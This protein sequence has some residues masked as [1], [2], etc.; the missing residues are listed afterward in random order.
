MEE[1]FPELFEY[2]IVTKKGNK[3]LINKTRQGKEQIFENL[4]FHSGPGETLEMRVFSRSSLLEN[5]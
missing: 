1:H 4:R 5:I 3:V 2:K